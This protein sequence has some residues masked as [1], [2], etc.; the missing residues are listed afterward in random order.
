VRRAVQHRFA[1]ATRKDSAQRRPRRWTRSA[2]RTSGSTA[3]PARS[4]VGSARSTS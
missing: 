1:N 3:R 2:S 4:I